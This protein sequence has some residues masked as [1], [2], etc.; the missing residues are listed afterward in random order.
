MTENNDMGGL[1]QTSSPEPENQID[2]PNKPDP[3]IKF[4][5]FIG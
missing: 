3:I 4:S 1:D 2:N 5:Y